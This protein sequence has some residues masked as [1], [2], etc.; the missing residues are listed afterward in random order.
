MGMWNA[1]LDRLASPSADGTKKDEGPREAIETAVAPV[2]GEAG[3]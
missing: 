2:K 3:P 1:L